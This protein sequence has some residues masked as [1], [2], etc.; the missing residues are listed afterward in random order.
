MM[1]QKPTAAAIFDK[2][3]EKPKRKKKK[4]RKGNKGKP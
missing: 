1:I 2:R 4:P 3:I